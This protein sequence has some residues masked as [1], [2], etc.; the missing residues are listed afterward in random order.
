MA[1]MR[2]VVEGGY[3][4]AGNVVSP[5]PV[6]TSTGGSSSTPTFVEITDGTNNATVTS[7][8]A[9]RVATGNVTAMT[10]LNAVTANA[11]GATVALGSAYSNWSA[12]GV[13]TGSPT[14]GTLTLEL[15]HDGISWV[16]STVTATISAAGN[17][18]LASTGR[19]ARFG[20]V[21]LTGLAGT[22]TL[23]VTMM[24]AG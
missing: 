21:N 12:I 10:T 4:A 5:L 18:L 23:T 14:G 17:F 3:N 24:A 1:E 8:N 2:V 19:P 7:L 15:S 22:I 13:A 16:S 11:T 9:V 6:T 20:R